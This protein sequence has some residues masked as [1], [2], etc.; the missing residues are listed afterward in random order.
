MV[1]DRLARDGA[2][3][4]NQRFAPLEY[5]VDGIVPEGMGLLVGP[6]KKGK[7][8]LV[9]NIGLA[10]A[11]GGFA[12]GAIR[13]TQRPV[14]YLALEDGDRRLQSRFR[15]LLGFGQPIPPG[16]RRITEA[17]A[18]G[19]HGGDRRVHAQIRRREAAGH[20]RHA[21]QGQAAQKAREDSY[22]VDYEVGSTLKA[23]ADAVPGSTLLVVHHTRK[24]EAADFVD[25][26]S[27]TQGI[28]GSVDFVLVL[29]R[30]RHEN[31]AILSVTGRDIVEAEYALHADDGVLW[32]LDGE[33]LAAA[34]EA[35]HQ[36]RAESNLG[37]RMMDVYLVVQAADG[38]VTAVDVA[39]QMDGLDNNAAGTY[40]RRLFAGGYITRVSRGVFSLHPPAATTDEEQEAPPTGSSDSFTSVSE[41]EAVK[42]TDITADQGRNCRFLHFRPLSFTP[43]ESTAEDPAQNM[44]NEVTEVNETGEE[45]QVRG[46][47][48]FGHRV[49]R[50]ERSE[51]TGAHPPARQGRDHAPTG[52]GRPTPLA[53]S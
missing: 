45:Q 48:R 17:F 35:V 53:P 36:R 50:R 52:K 4:D 27:G 34:Q 32:R 11:R 44:V 41:P 25:T 38:P 9:A 12:L 26:V 24:A 30:K 14:L 23:L 39:N 43:S 1:L 22:L 42:E 18:G 6:P 13:T 21:R 47:G 2:W 3:L 5:A 10:V 8:W 40:L 46:R 28:A 15:R 7:S 29:T 33:D 19:G 31:N 49:G 16:I 37:D 51:R 20:P